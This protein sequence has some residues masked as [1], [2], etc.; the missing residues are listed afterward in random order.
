MFRYLILGLLRT[1]ATLHGY[2]LVK[3]YRERSGADVSTGNFYRELQRLVMDGLIRCADNPPGADARRTPYAITAVG[4]EVFDE[5][6]AAA[7]AGAAGFAEDELSARALFLE[8]CEPTAW[9]AVL[10]HL[11]ENLWFVGKTLERTRQQ[12]L[13]RAATPGGGA[14]AILPLL[15]TRRLKHLA[16][17]LEFAE[18]LRVMLAAARPRGE[19]AHV[20]PRQGTTIERGRPAAATRVVAVRRR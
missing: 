2:A 9:A 1:G 13:A 14:A 11:Q 10:D 16:A 18:E 8:D 17:N 4:G 12:A 15:H 3:A 5:W 20:V 19:S 6:L 7:D